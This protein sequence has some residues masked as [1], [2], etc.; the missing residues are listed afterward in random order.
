[1][2]RVFT[3]GYIVDDGPF[4][5][6]ADDEHRKT[7]EQ[8]RLGEVP[9]EFRHLAAGAD[10]ILRVQL[11]EEQKEYQP[12]REHSSQS[13]A[14]ASP[15]SGEGVSLAKSQTPTQGT[16]TSV[17]VAAPYVDNQAP[18]TTLQVRLPTG[19]RV[20]LRVNRTFAGSELLHI[21]ADALH[22]PVTGVQISSGFPPKPFD[23]ELVKRSDI[24]QL[25]LCDSVV[26]FTLV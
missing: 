18:T 9:E 26:I 11:S 12:P 25:G 2:L 17:Q 5:D 7:L 21:V 4:R 20:T 16:S 19:Q 14:T 6:L 23:H 10:G 24:E 15:F 1:V 13:R 22:V 8:I 3:N